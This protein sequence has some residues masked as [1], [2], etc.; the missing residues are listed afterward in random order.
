MVLLVRY[1]ELSLKSR[2][3]RRQL[4]DRLAT[5]VQEMFAANGVECVLKLERGRVFVHADDEPA[6]VRLLQRVFGIVSISPA[7]EAPS[8]LPEL[9]EFVAGH[10]LTLLE[11]GMTFAIRP[12]RSGQHPYTSRDLARVLGQAVR[13]A[14]PGVSVDLGTPDREIHVEVRGPRA[15]VFH[16]TADGPGGLPL[17]SQGKAIAVAEDEAGMVAAWLIMRRG[18][19]VKVAGREPFVA[20]LRRW[21]PGL[22]T[23]EPSEPGPL[24]E[25]AAKKDLPL[26]VAWRFDDAHAQEPEKTFVLR[27]LAGLLD[28]EIERLAQTIQTD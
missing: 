26:V 21:D 19:R 7:K 10:A 12:Q 11:P 24:L 18:C 16:E 15:Y 20:A 14:I 5:N 1:G 27:P 8:D 22:G 23:L 13:D 3:V 28:E 2:Y 17:G 25:L 4:E 6:A 9:T